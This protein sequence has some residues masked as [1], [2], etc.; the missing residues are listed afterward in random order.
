MTG[1][2]DSGDDEE[3]TGNL[4]ARKTDSGPSPDLLGTS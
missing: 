4:G 3:R 2:L 1:L